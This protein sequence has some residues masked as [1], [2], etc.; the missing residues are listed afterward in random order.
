MARYLITYAHA[1]GFAALVR[2]A[3]LVAAVFAFLLLSSA[4]WPNPARADGEIEIV[5]ATAV[6]EFPEGF[7]F[8]LEVISETEI[9]EVKVNFEIAGRAANQYNYL[10]MEQAE[11]GSIRANL[12]SGEY[13]HRTNTRDRYSPPG[14]IINYSF[15]ITDVEGN[16]TTTDSEQLIYMDARFEW[17]TVTQGPVTTFFHGP[18]GVRATAMTQVALDTLANMGPLLGAEIATPL[19]II[20]YNNTAEMLGALAARSSAISRELI[21]EGQ[22]FGEQNV[23]LLLGNGRRAGGTIS[24]ELV[25]VLLSRATANSSLPVPLWMNEGLAEYGNVDQGIG[26]YRFLEWAVDTNRTTPFESLNVFPGDPNLSLVAYGQS[27]SAV[28]YI[29]AEFGREKMS[30]LMAVIDSGI[31]F[32]AAMV[33]T[34]GF[35][36]R[37]LDELWRA[38]VGAEPL[39][40]REGRSGDGASP[41]P[42]STR[43]RIAPL[44]LE[45]VAA[46]GAARTATPEPESE[47]GRSD[48]EDQAEASP[49]PESTSEAPG[50]RGTSGGCS[51]PSHDGGPPEAASAGL[52]L[53]P[54]A[55]F[56]WLRLRRGRFSS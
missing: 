35:D 38:E 30:E 1:P 55:V 19:R 40:D 17:E 3:A 54:F 28:E 18:V 37:G 23:V 8:N 11:N 13:F 25:H 45:S 21:T 47:P 51:A 9:D 5:R 14:T 4:A 6:S 41:T 33:R 44:T 52:L 7:R 22:A 56:A 2:S 42:E 50:E 29:I 26:Y 15:E 34:Y 46:A 31:P 43:T 16:V 49:A 36:T 20:M 24:H 48:E 39:P 10:D 32:N 12:V 27:R 53:M